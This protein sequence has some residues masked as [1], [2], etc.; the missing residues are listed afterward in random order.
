MNTTELSEPPL[1]PLSPLPHP[2]SPEHALTGGEIPMK[3]A[4][5]YRAMRQHISSRADV[6]DLLALSW[7]PE[8]ERWLYLVRTPRAWTYPKYA[9]GTVDDKGD[10]AQVFFRC[11]TPRTAWTEWHAANN[12]EHL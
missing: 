1:E 5:R 11:G 10:A 7:L 8:Q 9:V 6:S 2:A 12:G 3:E 4:H